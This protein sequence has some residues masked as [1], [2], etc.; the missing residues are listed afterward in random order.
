M[1]RGRQ[2]GASSAKAEQARLLWLDTGQRADPLLREWD[3]KT[4][5]LV[6]ALL[7]ILSTGCAVMLRVGSGG[8][9]VGIQIYE[10]DH[11][12]PATWVYD[13]EELDVWAD[14]INRSVRARSGEA[15][16]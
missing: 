13:T 9:S 8:R 11:K 12:H 7:E 2:D 5:P 15:A 3:P 14:R 1:P 16:D 6:S 4:E 10:G